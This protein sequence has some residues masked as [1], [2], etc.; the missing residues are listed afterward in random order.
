MTERKGE[1]MPKLKKPEKS[2]D[3]KLTEAIRMR[4]LIECGGVSGLAAPLKCSVSTI[5][6]RMRNPDEL[7]LGELRRIRDACCM[8][9]DEMTA[10]ITP[11]I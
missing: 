8:S 3:K 5:Y 11:M 4:A 10:L 1:I 7:T 2:P 6:G 9:R